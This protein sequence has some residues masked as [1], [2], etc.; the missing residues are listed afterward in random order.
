MKVARYYDIGDIRCE[1]TAQPR[2]GI[3]EILIRVRVCGLCGTDVSKMRE[4]N[5]PVPAVLGHEVAGDIAELGEGVQGFEVG[6]RIVVTHHVPCFVCN[7]C[8]HG[9]YSQCE[10][11]K[12]MNITPG[13]FSEYIRVL[14][15]GVEKSTFKIPAHLSYE[16]ACFT[17]TVA[18]CLRAIERCGIRAGDTVMIVGAG[19][20]GLLHLQLAKLFGAGRIIV[21]DLVDFRLDEASK[22]G[23]DVT[24]NI[25]KEK[26]GKRVDEVTDSFGADVVIVAVGSVAAL[27]TAFSFVSKGGKILFF[28]ECPRDSIL[29]LD[30]NLVYHSEVTL[31]GSYSSTPLEQRVALQL[32]ESGKIKVKELITHRRKLNELAGAVTLA[33]EGKESLKIIIEVQ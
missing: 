2:I 22:L 13:G 19:V 10:S 24:I 26:A 12:R 31:L 8:R 33:M 1:E 29:K 6:E 23:A 17:E 32:I 30:P 25:D 4:K 20:V 7:Y 3:G 5:V 9:N 27:G 21:T 11:F 28:A 18:C 16:E 15:P 14:P